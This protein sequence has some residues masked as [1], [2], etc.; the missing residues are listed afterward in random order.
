[1]GVPRF[2]PAAAVIKRIMRQIVAVEIHVASV[3]STVPCGAIR[4]GTYRSP[5]YARR[6]NI[7]SFPI[8][9][10]N[11]GQ[12]RITFAGSNRSGISVRL[13]TRVSGSLLHYH[14]YR[15]RYRTYLAATKHILEIGSDPIQLQP[16]AGW[17]VDGPISRN[18]IDGRQ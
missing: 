9:T 14:V 7:R 13:I 12:F 17:L 2:L 4:A 18:T 3:V 5:G 15:L 8:P 1:S 6:I 10:R 11:K 16:S